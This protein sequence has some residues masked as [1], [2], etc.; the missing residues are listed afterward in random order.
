LN[1]EPNMSHRFGLAGLVVGVLMPLLLLAAC[2]GGGGGGDSGGGPAPAPLPVT[3]IDTSGRFVAGASVSSPAGSVTTDAAGKAA[4]PV[5]NGSEFALGVAKSGFAE[6]VKLLTLP[7][8]RNA[9]AIVVM[10]IERDAAVTIAGI[11]GGGSASGRDGVKVTFPA[12]A[13]VTAAGAPVSGMIQMQMT[14]VNV[15]DLDVGAFPGAFE[16]LPTGAARAAIMSYGSAEL[17][18]LQGGQKLEL[19]AGKTAEIELP[20]YPGLHQ[21]GNAVAVGDTIA[22]WS[23]NAGTGLWTQEGSGTV[24]ANAASPTGKALRATI[25]HFSWWNGDVASEMATVNLSVAVPNAAP[26][27]PAGTL[28]AVSGQVVAGTGP[29]WVATT[30]VPLGTSVAVRVP[31]TATTRLSARVDL[32][33]QVCTG[34]IDV[35]PAANA[36]VD[37]TVSA[38]CFTTPVPVL[39]QPSSVVTTNS[40]RPIPIEVTIDGP[41]PDGVDVLVDGTPIAQL[42]P[43][44]FYRAF[45]DSSAFAEGSHLVSARAT[46]HGT[47]RDSSTREVVVDRTAPQATNIGPAATVEVSGSTVFSVDFDEPVNPLPFTL[48]DAVKLSVVPVNQITP[49]VIAATLAYDDTQRRLTVTPATPLPLGVAGLSWGGLKDSA[50]NAVA[51]TVA[52][53]WNVARTALLAE[54]G[55]QAGRVAIATNNA[56]A[57]FELHKRNSDGALVAARFDGGAFVPFGP[58]V[59]DRALGTDLVGSIAVDAGGQV[60]VAFAQVDVAG[61][62]SEVLVRRFDATANTWATLVAPFPVPGSVGSIRPLLRLNAAG[63][64]VLVFSTGVFPPALRG[65]RFDG[66]AWHDLGSLTSDFALPTMELDNDGNPVVALLRG[67]P[68]SNA[69]TLGVL[70]NTGAGWVALG[71]VLDSTP[72]GTQTIF[73][74]SLAIDAT[75]QPWVAWNHAPGRPVNLVQFDG[76]NFVPVAIVPVPTNGHPALTFIGGDPVLAVGDDS[77]Q[78]LRRHNGVWDTPLPVAVDGRGAIDAKASNGALIMGI[79]GPGLARVLRVAFP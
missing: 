48:A 22:L 49:L 79:G 69:A 71:G 77:S 68:G 15:V 61:T 31:A 41:V 20:I 44:F 10:L 18:P 62:A 36:T 23:L 75:G 3:V 51:G 11:E 40:A 78:V 56:G 39:V 50:G 76:T 21:G 37:A 5:A 66:T 57:V 46:L 4:V 55:D 28:A 73:E 25:G 52:A 47:S 35:A 17:L 74:P 26:P 60:F 58:V 64:P 14:P 43:Q 34:S 54:F 9:D 13:L 45:W 33:T 19:A 12:A 2:G 67:T 24:V 7:P 72:N 32:A 38:V 59:N 8:G 53:T 65:F 70:R 29:A 1:E 42:G 6:Q 30:S 63:L 16:G 27:A